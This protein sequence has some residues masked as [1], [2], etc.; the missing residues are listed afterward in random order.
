MSTQTGLNETLQD[1]AATI[2]HTPEA[3]WTEGLLASRSQMLDR[4]WSSFEAAHVM[5]LQSDTPRAHPY[6]ANKVHHRAEE[7][8]ITARG[9]LYD[10][11][12]RLHPEPLARS[13]PA[14]DQTRGATR[15][16]RITIPH[17]SGRREDWESFR[18]LFTSLIHED[19]NLSNVDK[20][21]YL[22]SHVQGDAKSALDDLQITEANYDIAWK[23]LEARYD[24]R[25][26]L[27][28]DHLKAL[29]NLSP[30]RDESSASLQ[31]LW[32]ELRRHRDQL[33]VLGR[34]VDSWDD[35]LLLFA[36]DAMDEVTRRDWEEELE[37]LYASRHSRDST[38][39]YVVPLTIKE[40]AISS[41]GKSLDAAKRAL[42]VA[43]RRM[44]RDPQLLV[45]YTKFMREYV[46][47][48]HMRRLSDQELASDS[49]LANYLPHH[50]IWQK[51]D[52]GKK[53]RVVFNAS[54]PTTSGRSLND[55]LHAGPKLQNNL[56]TVIT[57]WRRW[58]VAFCSDIRM[59]FRQ[60]WIRE[61]D[62]HLQRILWSP[63]PDEPEIH[64][65]LRTVTYGETCAPY[66][67]IRTL[68]QLCT[69]EGGPFPEAVKAIEQELYVDD[70]LCGADCLEAAFLRR[71]Q[72][73]QLLRAGG[74]SLKKWVS[75]DPR[76]L[77]DIA[78]EDHLRPSWLQLASDGPVNELGI[79]WDPTTDSLRF[80][81]PLLN[82]DARITKRQVLSEIAHLFDP[83]GWLAPV[84]LRAKLFMQDL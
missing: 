79:L 7:A 53:L 47:M 84:V 4:Y 20:L 66:L 78:P 16:P 39:R 69:D 17:F 43:Q 82:E 44:L 81:P 31:H 33:R 73:V 15:L 68:R 3:S 11:G 57:R 62:A 9:R 6:F 41:L 23:N 30:L 70:F 54:S 83:A 37:T 10:V 34:P 48:G 1:A 76:L 28:K 56:V 71:N 72:L 12:A 35:W 21:Y 55:V 75:N 45:E 26:L 22:K 18:D 60:I 40:G 51:Q 67:A 24:H 42:Q 52:R 46:E 77:M 19:S 65:V 13:T 64:Y 58:A 8:Y 32:D 80:A 59:M 63:S 49:H 38:E 14:P 5:L 25:R 74:F 29:K 27:V 61:E 50:G 36:A 2:Q